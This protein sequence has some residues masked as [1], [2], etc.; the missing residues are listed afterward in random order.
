MVEH[1]L[2][3]NCPM[4]IRT[5]II[6][7][8]RPSLERM[9][10]LLSKFDNIEIIGEAEDGQ[11]AITMI[12]ELKP[13]LALLDI[14]LPEFNSFEVLKQVNH[15]PLIVFVTAYDQYAIKAFE[16]NAV[17]YILKPTSE[18][19]LS[20]AIQ[21][22]IQLNQSIDDN[23]L[24]MLK[25]VVD[26]NDFLERFTVKIGDEILL[27]P[28]D[29]VYW[30]K[31]EDKYTFLNSY[32]KEYIYDSSLK[33]LEQVVDPDMFFRIHKNAIVN[34]NKIKKINKSFT[35]KYSVQMKDEKQTILEIGRT[36]LPDL[37]KKLHF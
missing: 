2:D 36:F 14:Q 33:Q 35:G 34:Q 27:I 3:W 11:S 10:K 19:R 1:R 5:V 12:D 7:D 37:R 20:K 8:E 25:N 28:V 13:D 29:D 18:E 16:E 32:D 24:R 21:K 30:F 31:A 26:R 6:E 9:K 4:K 15:H 17:D 23:I 22:V